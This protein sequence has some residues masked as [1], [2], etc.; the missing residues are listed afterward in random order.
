MV[1]KVLLWL[2]QFLLL[3][4]LFGQESLFLKAKGPYQKFKPDA[5]NIINGECSFEVGKEE[6]GENI[7]KKGRCILI[8]NPT[9]NLTFKSLFMPVDNKVGL[10]K[11]GD[12]EHANGRLMSLL[13]SIIYP[14]FESDA[15]NERIIKVECKTPNLLTTNKGGESEDLK[16]I[17]TELRCDVVCR[18]MI[19]G[20]NRMD[21]KGV[22]FVYFDI[23]MQ[24]ANVPGRIAAFMRYREILQNTFSLGENDEMRLVAFLNYRTSEATSVGNV[25][26][27][28]VIIDPKTK[29]VRL[30]DE[31]DAIREAELSKLIEL[32]AVVDEIQSSKEIKIASRS[33]RASGREW[34]KL[35]GIEWWAKHVKTEKKGKGHRYVVPIDVSCEKVKESL[36]I[37]S[38]RG[39]TEEMLRREAEKVLGAE[40]TAR[41]FEERG[42]KRG[43]E[44]G[45]ERGKKKGQEEEQRKQLGKLMGIFIKENRFSSDIAGIFEPNSLTRDFVRNVW[46]SLENP[47]KTKELYGVFC[48]E[49]ES[50]GL[51]AE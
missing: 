42:E 50:R 33:L 24:R 39:I 44:R 5:D 19:Q 26:V 43:E 6:G 38:H 14:D 34:L 47:D 2:V 25:V 37:L 16:N 40:A 41:A 46:N 8:A 36:K 15:E 31:K 30:V 4:S 17:L 12:K 49:L 35:L 29:E 9:Y 32:P 27:A 11:L 48:Q 23:E 45:E 51:I 3:G 10:E 1:K 7:W 13:N 18:C 21:K 20:T 28:A 22:F